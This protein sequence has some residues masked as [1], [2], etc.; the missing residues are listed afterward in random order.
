MKRK[1]LSLYSKIYLSVVSFFVVLLIVAA[2]V[3]WSLLDA[4]EETRPK[5]TAAKVFNSYFV[6][7]DLGALLQTYSPDRLM[8]E[9]RE[10]I[11][12]GF[13][14]EYDTSKLDY[15]S[16]SSGDDGSE[17]YVVSCDNHRIAYFTIA[18]IGKSAGFGFKQC[19]LS[20]VE[21][22]LTDH[23][24]VKAMVPNGDTLYINGIK[25]PD[26][27]ITKADI[28]SDSCQY[29][30]EGIDGIIYDEYTVS[31]LLFEPTV[32]VTSQSGSELAVTYDD[33]EKCYKVPLVYD[34]ELA[35]K[36]TDYVL[37]AA[38]E[39]TKYL[40]NDASFSAIAAYLDRSAE[41]YNRVRSVEVSWVRDHNG[42]KISDEKAS[43]FYRYADGVFS[44]RVTLKETLS[45]PGYADHS[46]Y[47][48]VTL[49]W[50][51]VDGKYLIYEIVNN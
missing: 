36:Q 15:F 2:A 16:V 11:N 38:R 13:S 7:A 9:N 12:S 42:Y 43:E 49:Y 10:S 28:K 40:S 41:I 25:V 26:S 20:D 35:A 4:Y 32:T 27:F 45:R 44:T 6:S 31:G 29:M 19:V 8:F 23:A 34:D 1:G 24:D 18:P 33:T 17:Q 48:D 46:E 39:Y 21:F 47:I 30:P 22:F 37:K 50:H 5:H 3:L 51:L 14:K